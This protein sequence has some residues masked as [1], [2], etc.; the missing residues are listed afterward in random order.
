MIFPDS[1]ITSTINIWEAILQRSPNLSR[2]ICNKTNFL[3][4]WKL[5]RWCIC[6]FLDIS[7]SLCGH[8]YGGQRA[9]LRNSFSLISQNRFANN[10]IF[11]SF[12][13]P[14]L[15]DF[16]LSLI[17]L[18]LSNKKNTEREVM[19]LFVFFAGISYILPSYFLKGRFYATKHLLVYVTKQCYI[20]LY[21]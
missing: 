10:W 13:L 6:C 2:I 4:S 21:S 5:F 19:F 18:Y 20:L 12:Y 8:L 3:L 1:E 17:L 16:T 7:Q 9:Y 14:S 15:Q 11:P